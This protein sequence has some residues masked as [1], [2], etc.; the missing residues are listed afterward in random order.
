MEIYL[1]NWEKLC[2]GKSEIFGL[3]TKMF[4]VPCF[5]VRNQIMAGIYPVTVVVM[6]T[7]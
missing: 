6:P 4:F 2:L 1:Q 5:S 7:L 3:V